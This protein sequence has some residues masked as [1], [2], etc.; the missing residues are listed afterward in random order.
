MDLVASISI[1]AVQINIIYNKV[2]L[3]TNQTKQTD[4]YALCWGLFRLAPIIQCIHTSGASKSCMLLRDCALDFLLFRQYTQHTMPN[5]VPAIKAP[6]ITAPAIA[7]PITPPI[8]IMNYLDYNVIIIIILPI[9]NIKLDV[10]LGGD[11]I[12]MGGVVSD[13]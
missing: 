12:V 9:F 7:I 6:T 5:T 10:G 1:I 8:P 2:L 11:E 4:R 13:D 3:P